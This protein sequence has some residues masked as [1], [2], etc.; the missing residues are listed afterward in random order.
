MS[1]VGQSA[2]VRIFFLTSI[3]LH[4][5]RTSKDIPFFLE[6]F[7]GTTDRQATEQELLVT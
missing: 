2:G 4:V 6:T 3:I 1:E 7:R 5:W